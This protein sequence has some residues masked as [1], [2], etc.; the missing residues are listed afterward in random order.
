MGI[1]N[2]TADLLSG[3]SKL[4]IFAILN[5][6][7]YENVLLI[8]FILLIILYIRQFS[9]IKTNRSVSTWTSSFFLCPKMPSYQHSMI[10]RHGEF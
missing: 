7:K 4:C 3:C 6:P 10:G 1:N 9:Y 5:F 2:S 8:K